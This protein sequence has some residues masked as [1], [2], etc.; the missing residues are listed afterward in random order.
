[1]QLLQKLLHPLFIIFLFLLLPALLIISSC[2]SNKDGVFIPV[3]KDT[4]AFGVKDHFISVEEI[5]TY[6]SAF[7]RVKDSI[8][9]LRLGL[10]VPNSEAFNKAAVVQLLQIPNCVGIKVAYGVLA[11]QKGN[12]MRLILVGVDKNGK[13]LYIKKGAIQKG[14]LTQDEGINAIEGGLEHGQCMPPCVY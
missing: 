11:G 8:L 10:S 5:K 3:P 2:N 13:E 4:T 6:K 9:Q 1:M 12:E 14:G 7:A